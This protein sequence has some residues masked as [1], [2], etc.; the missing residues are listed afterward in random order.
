MQDVAATMVRARVE[1]GDSGA[2]NRA[3]TR[4]PRPVYRIGQRHGRWMLIAPDGNPFISLLGVVHTGA[5]PGFSEEAS[6]L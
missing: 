2:M 4:Q 6:D 5:V 1:H 3:K